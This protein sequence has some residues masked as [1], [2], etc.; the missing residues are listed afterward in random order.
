MTISAKANV[1]VTVRFT[2]YTSFRLPRELHHHYT[3]TGGGS[4]T[5]P[6]VAARRLQSDGIK[7]CAEC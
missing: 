6:P 4:Q 5:P 1:A 3:K 2:V 7:L